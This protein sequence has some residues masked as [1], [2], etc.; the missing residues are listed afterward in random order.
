VVVGRF[1]AGDGAG[2]KGRPGCPGGYN[3]ANWEG[4]IVASKEHSAVYVIMKADKTGY[5][6]T[7]LE[8]ELDRI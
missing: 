5:D 3:I 1:R 4:T 2:V 6:R 7:I 8:D